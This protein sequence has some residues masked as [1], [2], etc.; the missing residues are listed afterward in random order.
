MRQVCS[1]IRRRTRG[2]RCALAWRV[3]RPATPQARSSDVRALA[4][5][6]P[7]EVM[8]DLT[9][10]ESGE[11]ALRA[12]RSAAGCRRR[13]RSSGRVWPAVHSSAGPRR[14][15]FVAEAALFAGPRLF[16]LVHV[17]AA[18]VADAILATVLVEER[19][20]LLARPSAPRPSSPSR[21]ALAW[22]P[23][24]SAVL[25]TAGMAAAKPTAAANRADPFRNPR[26]STIFSSLRSAM[27]ASPPILVTSPDII[28]D[29][30]GLSPGA[31]VF[32]PAGAPPAARMPRTTGYNRG[33][34][35]S[36]AAA[37]SSAPVYKRVL[38][39]LS[40]EALMGDQQFGVD[41]A[42]AT[43]I[44]Q[45]VGEIQGLGVQTAIVIGGGNIFRGLAASARG[46]TARPPITWACSRRS[47]T[48]WRCR[49][50]SSSKVS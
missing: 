17:A 24:W 49:M 28:H 12:C 1:A 27:R 40:G 20:L 32:S 38:L 48:H 39:K 10:E 11:R 22:V 50:P 9:G 35:S 18:H 25:R 19:L 34:M 42:V 31:A 23:A 36:D 8:R 29:P 13:R 6:V 2:R 4:D 41:P 44:A 30:D 45:D 46:W 5:R 14:L 21:R 26:R 15:L 47:S 3:R 37:P 16:F 33:L 43:R 7:A